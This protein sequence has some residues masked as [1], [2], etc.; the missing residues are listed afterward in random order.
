M[1]VFILCEEEGLVSNLMSMHECREADRGLGSEKK[2][3]TTIW[4]KFRLQTSYYFF[5][6]CEFIQNGILA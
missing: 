2:G 6:V 1:T 3:E 5:V 4:A